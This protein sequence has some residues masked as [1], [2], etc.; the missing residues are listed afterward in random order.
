MYTEEKEKYNIDIKV[1]GYL[2]TQRL[3]N[4]Q[5]S[6]NLKNNIIQMINNSIEKEEIQL[7]IINNE[8][9]NFEKKLINFPK[10]KYLS[11]MNH[12]YIFFLQDEI[13]V[14]FLKSKRDNKDPYLYRIPIIF[15]NENF[16]N[17]GIG[18]TLLK[19][20]FNEVV[21]NKKYQINLDSNQT[22]YIDYF[23]KFGFEIIEDESSS[24]DT[25][26][27]KISQNFSNI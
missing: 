27:I 8:H 24:N 22:K 10:M 23:K 25:K 3:F 1:L 20:Y 16:R 21:V 6:E 18:E 13:I 4:C 11:K 15:V 9:L 2:Q 12:K 19:I 14:G 17:I 5:D 26:M 7:K